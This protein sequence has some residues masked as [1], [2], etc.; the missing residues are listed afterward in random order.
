MKNKKGMLM[1]EFMKLVIGAMCILVLIYI[2]YAL[3]NLFIAKSRT[4][5]AKETMKEI[6]TKMDGLKEGQEITYLLLTPDG[7]SLVAWPNSE[8]LTKSCSDK[9]WNNCLCFC[10][11]SGTFS[12]QKDNCDEA[13]ICTNLAGRKVSGDFNFEVSGMIKE[14]KSLSISLNGGNYIFK[15]K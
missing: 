8:G 7:Y 12:N 9:G 11:T 2:V 13:G 5:Q 1:P 14:K 10:P 15:K 6:F 4:E 3:T